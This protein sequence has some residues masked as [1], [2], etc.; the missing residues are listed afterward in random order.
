VP[1]SKPPAGVAFVGKLDP[2]RPWADLKSADDGV[3]YVPSPASERRGADEGTGERELERA[4]GQSM[5]T[6]RNRRGEAERQGEE[7]EAGE[8]MAEVDAT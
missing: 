4:E 1:A 6:R 8:E 7:N 5:K 2:A 3:K